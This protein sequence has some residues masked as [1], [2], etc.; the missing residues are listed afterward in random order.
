M[1]RD[2]NKLIT[3]FG[4]AVER[5]QSRRAA[6]P[7]VGALKIRQSAWCRGGAGSRGN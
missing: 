7:T 2:G 3:P 1:V 5:H 6:G 4:V